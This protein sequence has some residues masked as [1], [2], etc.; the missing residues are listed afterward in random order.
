[1]T[2][3]RT[4]SLETK[5]LFYKST[6]L[7]AFYGDICFMYLPLSSCTGTFI[8]HADISI[9]NLERFCLS[10]WC[11]RAIAMVVL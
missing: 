8:V 7:I 1:M 2:M 11:D 9:I 4:M 3:R 5:R 10:F 6:W